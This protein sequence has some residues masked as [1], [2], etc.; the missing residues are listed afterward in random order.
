M[1]SLHANQTTVHLE[2]RMSFRVRENFFAGYFQLSSLSSFNIDVKIAF[3]PSNDGHKV[4]LLNLP[5]F[6]LDMVRLSVPS[7]GM[8]FVFRLDTVSAR[9]LLLGMVDRTSREQH[10]VPFSQQEK[11]AVYELVL[12]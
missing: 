8:E 11:A 2:F 7:R 9:T 10:S 4:I 1:H 5:F 12:E 6:P 3:A